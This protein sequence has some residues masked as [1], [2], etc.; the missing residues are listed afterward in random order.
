[1]QVG[2]KKKKKKKVDDKNQKTINSDSA[3]YGPSL[4]RCF[5]SVRRLHLFLSVCSNFEILS[6]QNI[7]GLFG[8]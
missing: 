8:L 7:G 2:G 4:K 5:S 6:W 1:M 3:P